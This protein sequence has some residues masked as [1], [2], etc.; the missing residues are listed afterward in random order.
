MRHPGIR[1]PTAA[2]SALQNADEYRGLTVS[3]RLDCLLAL[4]RTV[5]G[6]CASD[7]VRARQLAERDRQKDAELR[8]LTRAQEEGHA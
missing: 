1:F 4:I 2:E 3:Q 8:A 6:V 7:A 5:E